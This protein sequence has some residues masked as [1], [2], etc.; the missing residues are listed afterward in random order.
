MISEGHFFIGLIVML[1]III[2]GLFYKP[3]K[4]DGIPILLVMF[5]GFFASL[6]LTLG[7]FTFVRWAD[8]NETE[9]YSRRGNIT[10]IKNSNEV[11]GSFTLG[12]GT[13]EQT[14]YYY[15]YYKS[16]DGYVRGKKP[17]NKTF[18]VE[19]GSDRP[20]V[21]VKM[22]HFESKSGLIDYQ[23]EEDEKYKIVVPKGTVVN[24]FEVY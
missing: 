10:S 23:D 6:L 17:V 18:I 16:V 22:K 11:G 9:Y 20:H 1:T 19:D 3:A 2:T 12:C 13:I 21:E 15:Y 5:L 4:D 8:S 24:K 7:I 14:E